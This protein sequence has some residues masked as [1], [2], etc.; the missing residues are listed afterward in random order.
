MSLA[1]PCPQGRQTDGYGPRGN[2]AGLGNLGFHTG[3]DWAAPAGTAILAAQ[4]GVVT[5]KWWDAF[6]NGAGAGGNM[7]AIRGDNGWETR[8]AHM[9]NQSP[10]NIGQR[11]EAGQQVGQVGSSGAATGAHLHFELLINGQYV[12]PLPYIGKPQPIPVRKKDKFMKIV[13]TTK[14]DV[15]LATEDGFAHLGT[16]HHVDLFKRLIKSDVDKFETY[17]PEEIAKMNDVLHQLARS[18]AGTFEGKVT[19]EV[20]YNK[21]A[22][23]VN[24]DAAQRMQK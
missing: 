3:Q 14:G 13:Q 1:H 9:L 6:A 12:N 21:I 22:Q 2:V 11:V 7:I 5:R 4:D 19:A 17:Y 24:D 18:N 15:Y 16:G 20:D 23:T 8:Y 10:L